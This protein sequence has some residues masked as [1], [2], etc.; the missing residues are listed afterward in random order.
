MAVVATQ[1]K[2]Y[3][4]FGGIFIVFKLTASGSYT[5]GGDLASVAGLVPNSKLPIMY[6]V[7]GSAG[8]IYQ[9]VPGT[10]Q[11]NGKLKVLVATT[12]GANL[13]LAEH[14]AA[15]YVGGVSGDTILATLFFPTTVS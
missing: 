6:T 10:T 15:A 14:T 9:W 11:A 2:R 1:V 13:P 4:T 3:D 5:T 8:F 7:E 12:T